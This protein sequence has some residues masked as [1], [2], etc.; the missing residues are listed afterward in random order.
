MSGE[1]SAYPSIFLEDRWAYQ[2][3][4]GWT[5]RP[6]PAGAKLLAKRRSGFER[7]LV[8]IE[9]LANLATVLPALPLGARTVEVVLHDFGAQ[10]FGAQGFGAPGSGAQGFGSQAVEAMPGSRRFLPLAHDRRLLNIATYVI[11]LRLTE[12][13]LLAQM[14]GDTRRKI[15]KAASA[16]V[17]IDVHDDPPADMVA[18]FVA[19][20][21]VLARERS[22]Q[23]V[24][25]DTYARMYRNGDALL[26]VARHGAQEIGYLHVYRAG[27]S[28][29][30]MTGVSPAKGNDGAN[31]LL[32]WEIM[33]DL[34]RRGVTWY[35][36]GGV[37]SFDDDGD[38]I[39]RFK[40]GFGGA[41]VPLGREW[42]YRPRWVDG[43]LA[44]KTFLSRRRDAA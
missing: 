37:R 4:F 13:A 8:M 34:K 41:P 35:D 9:P 24:D 1:P 11:D 23:R 18:R 12:D 42:G 3:Y 33:R 10:G 17:A 28:A 14:S 32:H 40:K 19:A 21:D 27:P 39:A 26:Y 31:H 38:G 2:T 16:G 25:G 36:L 22:L 44:L 15:R 5:E 30:F 6:G 20:F 43:A 7:L 29:V